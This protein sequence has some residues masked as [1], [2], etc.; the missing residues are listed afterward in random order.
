MQQV[1]GYPTDTSVLTPTAL[2]IVNGEPQ[3]AS[4]VSISRELASSM[5]AQVNA[6]SGLTAAT[7]SVV[8][9]VGDDVQD[10]A[11]HPWD[12]NSFPPKPADEVVIFAGYAGQNDD[13][14]VL[15][16]QLTGSIDGTQGSVASGNVSSELVD[17]IDKLNQ[18]VSF[19]ALMNIM[20][21][22]VEGDPILYVGLQP[23]FITDR[24]LR[25]CGFHATPPRSGSCVFS[26]PNM[27]SMWP[28]V[29]TVTRASRQG[30]ASSIPLHAN[31]PWGVGLSSGDADYTPDLSGPG[32]SGRLNRVMQMTLK[33]D[34][35]TG[36]SG[37]SFI[38]AAWGE[39]YITMQV[40]PGRTVSATLSH[41][42]TT[43]TVCTLLAADGAS[44]DTFTLRVTPGGVFTIL[45]NNGQSVSGSASLPSV[46]TGTAMTSARTLVPDE[47]GVIIGGAQINFGSTNVVNSVPTARLT[48][49]ASTHS[50]PAFPR[51]ESRNALDLL[52]EQ[53]EA[54][55]ASIWIDEHGRF[56][57]I[58]RLV[59]AS[60]FPAATLTALDD[61]LDIGWESDASSVRSRVVVTSRNAS[62]R[63]SRVS[64]QLAWQG[65][66]ASLEAMEVAEEIITPGADV[67]WIEVDESIKTLP[68]VGS[69][70]DFN[71]GR[72]TWA[73]GVA[74]ND[75]GSQWATIG[76]PGFSV[77]LQRIADSVYSLTT[78]AGFPPEGRT[79]EL[80]T[81]DEDSS[82]AIWRSKRNLDLPL[83]RAKAV[84]EWSDRE[85]VGLHVGPENAAVLEHNVGP[86]IQL[87]EEL[88]RVADWLSAR[89]FE[90]RP[91]LRNLSVIPDFRRQLG[92]I[93]WVEGQQEM[94][95]RLRLL[96]TKL[97]T[98]VS[99]GSAEQTVGGRILEVQSLGATNAQLDVHAGNRANTSFDTLWAD[100]NNAQLDNDPLGR[101]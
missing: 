35:N 92:D 19:P 64:S 13:D 71:R 32:E 20:P 8:W 73:G 93:V 47:T 59:A 50:L 28:E 7:G 67:D 52:K 77:E 51:I 84:V 10:R 27:G 97:D 43:F 55:C 63:R 62:V 16:R 24:I 40:S 12:G 101:G 21:P 95:I 99:V 3:E 42:L 46:M 90:P 6:T 89:L 44:A 9:N 25:E 31:T 98:T 72:G 87:F 86:W 85:T 61:V 38:R 11:A 91:V 37:E 69:I 96:I 78:R 100:V 22:P 30:A 83:I 26:A 58:N 70:S 82:T 1:E 60:S 74:T 65:R 57:L 54:E 48:A 4:S 76:N 2:V 80:R 56:R 75:S 33:L 18:P 94:N 49:A 66:G 17:P 53:A 29:G 45:A 36:T 81:P 41:N 23:I 79:V 68:S 34:P 39:S 15:V 5:P 14:D 88:V